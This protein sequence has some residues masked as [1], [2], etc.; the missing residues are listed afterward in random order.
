MTQR[1][2]LPDAFHHLVPNDSF[3]C[4]APFKNAKFELFCTEN[5]SWQIWLGIQIAN[6][7]DSSGYD[8]HLQQF[9]KQ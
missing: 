7:C 5:A 3:H 1:T 9:Y 8:T 4:Q 2:R 6:F